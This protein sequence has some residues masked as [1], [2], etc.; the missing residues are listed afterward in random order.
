[1]CNCKGFVFFVKATLRAHTKRAALAL[2]AGAYNLKFGHRG[3]NHPVKNLKTAKIGI[4]SQNRGF[5]V[6]YHPEASPGPHDSNSL[7]EGFIDLMHP[8][9]G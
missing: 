3:A 2:G 6:Q 4:T 7:F 9:R 5:C 8:R 1:L